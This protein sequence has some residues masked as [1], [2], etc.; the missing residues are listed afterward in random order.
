VSP[1]S[2]AEWLAGLLGSGA[3]PGPS[4]AVQLVVTGGP[5]GDAHAHVR[6][7]DGMVA[8][9]SPVADAAA[10]VTLTAS[11]ADAAA[12]AAGSLDPSV[13][14]MQGRVKTAGDPGLVLDLLGHLRRCVRPAGGRAGR[15]SR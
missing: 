12:L 3:A 7:A 1:P 4:V 14:F 15:A 11:A 2:S 10:D 5:D 6:L 13:A 9:A 8:Q